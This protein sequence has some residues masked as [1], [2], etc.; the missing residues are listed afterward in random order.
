MILN[1]KKVKLVMEKLGLLSWL[2]AE[3]SFCGLVKTMIPRLRI[4][5]NA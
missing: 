1:V 5:I 2:C 3:E 4:F